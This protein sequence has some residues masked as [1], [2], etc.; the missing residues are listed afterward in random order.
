MYLITGNKKLGLDLV[1]WTWLVE[2]SDDKEVLKSSLSISSGGDV[3]TKSG[4][5]GLKLLPECN[6]DAGKLF[7]LHQKSVESVATRGSSTLN[8]PNKKKEQRNNLYVSLR[9]FN[10]SFTDDCEIS[11]ALFDGKSF[12]SERHVI[13]HTQLPQSNFH[14]DDRPT[15][16]K[17]IPNKG[18][19][20]LVV[21]I[22]RI[23]NKVKYI[24]L[25]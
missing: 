12:I 24:N 2:E 14:G 5:Q 16:F 19:L 13:H 22:V 7:K 3:P 17:E 10:Y 23:G 25:L 6:R 18:D 20:Y 21:Q 4:E 9:D 15:I 8:R 1:P 11:F